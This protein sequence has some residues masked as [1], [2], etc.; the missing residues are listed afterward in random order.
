MRPKVDGFRAH[1][2][3]KN[4]LTRVFMQGE[5]AYFDF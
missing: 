5:A 2:S 1:I 3:L 4:G